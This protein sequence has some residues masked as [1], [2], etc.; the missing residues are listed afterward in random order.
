MAKR[1]ATTLPNGH[2]LETSSPHEAS[3]FVNHGEGQ[4]FRLGGKPV[5]P[6]FFFGTVGCDVQIAWEK[7]NKTHERVRCLHGSSVAGFVEKWVRRQA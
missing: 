5:P 7:K 3:N 2:T 1:Y 4:T 6:E